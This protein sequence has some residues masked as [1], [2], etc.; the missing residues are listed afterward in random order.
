MPAPESGG[1]IRPQACSTSTRAAGRGS[2][3]ANGRSRPTSGG[4]N[5][6]SGEGA[7]PWQER[8]DGSRSRRPPTPTRRHPTPSG[9]TRRERGR[10][11]AGASRSSSG[12]TRASAGA[13]RSSAEQP[14]PHPSDDSPRARR[15]IRV[16]SPSSVFQ[17]ASGTSIQASRS[18]AAPA[19]VRPATRRAGPCAHL[20]RARD[21]RSAH[22]NRSAALLHQLDRPCRVWHT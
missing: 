16:S 11:P 4:A 19:R 5:D 20:H 12:A 18:S 9:R 10:S 13:T 21:V 7:G 8:T 6:S 17:R 14:D 2:R 22:E 1:R 15:R 3:R